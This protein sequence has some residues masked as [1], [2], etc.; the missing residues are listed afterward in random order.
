VII[1]NT[2]GVLMVLFF[3]HFAHVLIIV[4]VYI[5]DINNENLV[6]LKNKRKK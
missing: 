3:G 1:V 6:T 5:G 2:Q 4:V